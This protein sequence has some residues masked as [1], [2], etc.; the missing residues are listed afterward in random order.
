MTNEEIFNAI[1]ADILK[2]SIQERLGYDLYDKVMN[3]MYGSLSI[4][5]RE[6]FDAF[7]EKEG[8]VI[9]M[10]KIIK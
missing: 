3:G 10:Q 6:K 1:K 2:G 4:V 5:A 8:S 7:I 9:V